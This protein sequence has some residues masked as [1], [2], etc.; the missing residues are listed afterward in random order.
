MTKT[1]RL[2]PPVPAE[3]GDRSYWIQTTSPDGVDRL[4]A[5][6]SAVTASIAIVGGGLTGLWTAWRILE[7]DPAADVV[8][9]EADFCGSGASGRNGGQVHTWF[10][11]LDYLRAVTGRAEAIRLARAT[12]DAIAEMAQL[13]QDDVLAMDLRLDGFVSYSATPAHDGNWRP[14][15]ALLAEHEETPYRELDSAEIVEVTGTATSRGGM[16]EQDA[17]TM[18]PFK[19][20]MSLRERLIERGARIYESTPVTS[21]VTGDPATLHTPN[22]SVTAKRVLIATNAWAGSIP[23]INRVMYAVDGQ[24]I[25]TEPL[26]DKLAQ[27]GLVDGKA[28][29][30]SQMQVLYYQRTVDG[31]LLLGQGSGL[32][33][34]R[35]RLTARSNRNPALEAGVVSEMERMYPSLSGAR[36]DY[37]WVGPI[38]ISASHLPVIDTLRGADNILYCVGYT[39]TALA[40]IPVVARILAAQLQGID[41]EWSRS[42]LGHQRGRITKIFP[43]PFRFIG[44]T[45]VRRAVMRRVRMEMAGRRVGPFT[46]GLIALMP[47][48]RGPGDSLG[49]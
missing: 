29:G 39:G 13:Q 3:P 37:A 4:S 40:Q 12:R 15:F 8:V 11:N 42:A 23:Q 17:G 22:G 48:Y 36:V 24:V 41:D 2:R 26:P 9:V 34:Y 31:R 32:P 46:K 19:L 21:I 10:G 25:T 45:I 49:E 1:Y 28:L 18:N 35:D 47:R 44:A 43:E 14:A 20:V 33:I 6:D 30:D 7:N 16:L 27:T 5:L 38:D